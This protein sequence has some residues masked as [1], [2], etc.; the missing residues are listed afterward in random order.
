M[1]ITESIRRR[2]KST[3]S[4]HSRLLAC[5]QGIGYMYRIDGSLTGHALCGLG[6]IL[7]LHLS[8][9][10][11]HHFL[12]SSS[13]DLGSFRLVLRPAFGA[14]SLRLLLAFYSVETRCK[15]VAS[16]QVGVDLDLSCWPAGSRW[17]CC[18][19]YRRL[20]RWWRLRLL[21]VMPS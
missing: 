15:V 20:E 12:P 8:S 1:A 19:R 17:G 9:R 10:G 5:R 3:D 11:K 7:L 13:Q 2:I 16:D 6:L 18:T 4:G 21:S 14:G